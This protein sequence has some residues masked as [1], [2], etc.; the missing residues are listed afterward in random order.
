VKRRF[1]LWDV[2]RRAGRAYWQHDCVI[3]AAAISYFAVMYS[4]HKA[5]CVARL[6]ELWEERSSPVRALDNGFPES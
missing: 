5:D 4:F 2:L 3:L 6:Q 1:L